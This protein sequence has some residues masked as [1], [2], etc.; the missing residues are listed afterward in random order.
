MNKVYR[1]LLILFVLATVGLLFR[2]WIYRK[3][4]T[5]KFYKVRTNY[6]VTDIKLVDYINLSANNQLES[7]IEQI[8]KLGLSITSRQ[9]NFTADYSN[10]EDPNKLISTRNA[11]C[12]GYASFFAS[13]CNYILKKYNHT[14]NWIAVHRVAKLKIIGIDIHDFF[15]SPFFTDH[16]FVTI[17]NKVTGEIIAVDPSINDYLFI[18]YVTYEK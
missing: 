2:G 1:I 11:H 6:L 4:V 13:T 17:E 3:L 15:K 9:L 14:N 16:D 5:Y 8:I 18:D 7:D 10:S 12:V